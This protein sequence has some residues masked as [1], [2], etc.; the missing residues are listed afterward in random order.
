VNAPA[1]APRR[2][3]LG[4]ISWAASFLAQETA[5]WTRI[6]KDRRITAE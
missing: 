6:I 1:S 5:I 4:R 3:L 2:G